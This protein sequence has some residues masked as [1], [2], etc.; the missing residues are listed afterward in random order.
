MPHNLLRVGLTTS[1]QYPPKSN[2]VHP[3]NLLSQYSHHN[4]HSHSTS[5]QGSIF[6]SAIVQLKIFGADRSAKNG[7]PFCAI[8]DFNKWES[9]GIRKGLCDQVEEGVR[10]LEYS[11]YRSMII[12]M[13]HKVEAQRIVLTLLTDLVQHMLKLH[14]MTDTQFLWYRSI[15]EPGCD[16]GNW[17]LASQ[18]VEAVFAGTWRSMSIGDDAFKETGNT[19]CAMYLWA[20]YRLT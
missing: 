8:L 9:T 1:L 2:Y 18:F 19:R 16:D 17:I 10:A 11:L 4:I 13:M 20:G 5:S 6:G 3:P 15:L 7:R 12:H 14:S